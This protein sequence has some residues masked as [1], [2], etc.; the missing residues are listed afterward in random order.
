MRK[1]DILFA[2]SFE[3]WTHLDSLLKLWCPQEKLTSEHKQMT[4]S[5]INNIA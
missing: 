3:P 5:Q 2:L 4:V 1:L